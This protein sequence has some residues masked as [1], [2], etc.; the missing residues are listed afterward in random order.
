MIRLSK[1]T[2]Y[3]ILLLTLFVESGAEPTL[4]AR[5]LADGAGIPL[6]TVSKVLK[7]LQRD[8]L[9]VSQRGARGGYSLARAASE[10]SVVDIVHALEGGVGLT[11]CVWSPGECAHEVTCRVS[12]NWQIINDAVVGALQ[13]ISLLDMTGP[14]PHELMPLTVGAFSAPPSS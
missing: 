12:A 5:A 6:P 1:Q 13:Q 8:G 9:L 14:L 2:D 4:T 11:E 10:I 3:G 7:L